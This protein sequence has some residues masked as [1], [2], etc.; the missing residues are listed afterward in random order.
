MILPDALLNTLG[1]PLREEPLEFHEMP[2]KVAS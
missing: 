2:L 1:E